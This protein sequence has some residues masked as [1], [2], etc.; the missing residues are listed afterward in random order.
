MNKRLEIA[1][2]LLAHQSYLDISECLSRADEL[3]RLEE[4]TRKKDKDES[5]PRQE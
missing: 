4:L 1:S 2:R 5:I 3:I